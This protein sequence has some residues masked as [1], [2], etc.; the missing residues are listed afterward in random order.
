MQFD[1]VANDK[2]TGTMQKAEQ[3]MGNFTKNLIGK[4]T[5][6]A[7]KAALAV[8]A[9]Q[10]LFKVI[11]EAGDYADEAAKLGLTAETYQRLK[12]A[13]EDYGASVENIATALKD[14]NKMLDEAATKGGPNADVLKAL[15]FSQQDIAD[16]AI[17]A[18]EVFQR[19]SQAIK[20]A[21]TE[22]EKFA[23]ASRIVGDRVAQAMVPILADYDNFKRTAGEI[24]VVTNENAV[25][26]DAFGTKVGTA[27]T[28]LK[29][30]AVNA[31]GALAM[32]T[33]IVTAAEVAAPTPLSPEETERRQR[34]RDALLAAGAKTVA[35]KEANM[36]VT[37]LQQI[38]GGIAR[39]PSAL[40][41]YAER[42]AN[43]TE[44]L[45]GIATTT[46]PAATGGTDVTSIGNVGKVIWSTPDIVKTGFGAAAEEGRRAAKLTR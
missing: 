7:A 8:A 45:A 38:G 11:S 31:L 29:N 42:T 1:I 41:S 25:A 40:E 44:T 18:E 17:K 39:G 23:I 12:F 30:Q 21:R 43:A 26:F 27:L 37:T 3:G 14:V 13:A 4:Y 36:A 9:A 10:R 46:P 2:A 15:G 35:P 19:I 6:I 24:S 28:T 22:E 34:M 5:M 32:K 33:G 20:E 16:R